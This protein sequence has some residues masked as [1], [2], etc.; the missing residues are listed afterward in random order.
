M[1]C[2]SQLGSWI[3][4]RYKPCIAMHWHPHIYHQWF[5]RCPVVVYGMTF[6]PSVV[7]QLRGLGH[8]TCPCSVALFDAIESTQCS[9]GVRAG[10]YG[11]NP[12]SFLYSAVVIFIHPGQVLTTIQNAIGFFQHQ[13]NAI[14]QGGHSNSWCTLCKLP[15][16]ETSWHFPVVPHTPCL[17]LPMSQPS[18]DPT[19]WPQLCLDSASCDA[20]C[21][22]IWLL[23]YMQCH[24]TD[25]AMLPPALQSNLDMPWEICMEEYPKLWQNSIYT[26]C[27]AGC[28]G[29]EVGLAITFVST[30]RREFNSHWT[31]LTWQP[32]SIQ[33]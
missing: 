11:N 18:R 1:S 13:Y 7:D 20:N 2:G 26:T 30:S 31:L 17:E 28:L 4:T 22:I 21:M 27:K 19:V 6:Q 25:Y 23:H 3:G 9:G 33:H 29:V 12:K 14:L 5:Y 15:H 16:Y 24:D 32:S 8:F 10:N